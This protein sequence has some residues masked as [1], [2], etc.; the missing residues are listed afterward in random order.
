MMK[1]DLEALNNTGKRARI[2]DATANFKLPAAVKE[3]VLGI[4]ARNKVSEAT[5]L[6]WALNEYLEARG[7]GEEK[8]TDQTPE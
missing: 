2:H 7:Y 4:A 6:R 1:V 3:V 5:V 8:L